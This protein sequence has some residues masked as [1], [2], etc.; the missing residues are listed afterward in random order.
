MPHI[1]TDSPGSIKQT[2]RLS[3]K[4][5]RFRFAVLAALAALAVLA[6][7]IVAFQGIGALQHSNE[8]IETISQILRRH[9]YGDMMHDAINAD[10][11]TARLARLQNDSEGVA[12]AT[13]EF[14]EHA[15]AFSKAIEANLAEALPAAL[16]SKMLDVKTALDAYIGAGRSAL[17]ALTGAGDSAK[18]LAIF[19]EKFTFLEENNEA[20]S[21]GLSKWAADAKTESQDQADSAKL[22][23]GVAACL[24][25]LF[26][27]ALPFYAAAA[28][29]RP[30]QR[31]QRTMA[32]IAGG[33]T[34]EPVPYVERGDE[35]GDVARAVDVFRQSTIRVRE[36]TSE[37]VSQQER[38]QGD[39]KRMMEDLARKFEE[40]VQSM[41]HSVG[42]VASE[43]LE[44]SRGMNT[45]IHTTHDRA[46]NAATESREASN[47][48]HTIAA[49]VEEMSSAS[50][51]IA[52][53]IAL[54]SGLVRETVGQVNEA[55][56]ASGQLK[57]ANAEIGN[58]VQLIQEITGQINLLALN[59]TIE[60]A[61]AGEAGKGFAVVASEVKN[62][63]SQT[64]KATEQIAEQIGNVQQVAE[65]VV[66]AF[67]HIKRSIEKVDEFSVRIAAS[68]EEQTATTN[69]IAANMSANAG[70]AGAITENITQVMSASDEANGAADRVLSSAQ[71][72]SEQ[73]TSLRAEVA[74]FVQDVRAA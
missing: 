28:L 2:S 16:K 68:A 52:S 57:E 55:E 54:S 21:E 72:L 40:R 17:A 53:Q 51:E 5:I 64:S 67:S 29:F 15:E 14:A 33:V 62:L 39:K 43:L 27:I 69:D 20:L 71:H 59:A 49:A 23:I 7:T 47:A 60:S 3:A 11:Q 41:I 22:I 37:Q 13:K 34:G 63:A 38:A 70:R 24:A 46:A 32:D 1:Q 45:V 6:L 8:Q 44:T 58:I 25:L 42:N 31:M 9:M 73:S 56:S 19:D 12:T 35:M 18:D 74:K 30:L 4:S 61:R 10:M 50:R 26:S 36:I 65:K 66:Q 48:A